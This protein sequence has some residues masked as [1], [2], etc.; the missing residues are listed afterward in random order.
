MLT[1]AP[2]VRI[3]LAVAPFNMHGSYDALAGEVR[4]LHL[5][6]LDGHLYV[7]LNARRTSMKVLFFDRSGY[8]IYSKRLA[9][10]TF[11]LPTVPTGAT[12]LR[13]DSTVLSM[14]LDGVDLSAPRRL[15][16]REKGT[17]K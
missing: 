8:C 16:Y 11:E 7:F 15:R 4:R 13:V 10:G 5:N 17:S 2:S 14:I 3:F 9:R 6:P 1:L 12:Q